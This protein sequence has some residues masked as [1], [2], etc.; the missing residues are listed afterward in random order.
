MSEVLQIKEFDAITCEAD[1]RIEYGKYRL[2]RQN[3]DDLMTFVRE[4]TSDEEQADALEFM[5]I[6]YKRNAGDI[7]SF[8][9][10]VGMIQLPII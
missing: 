6:R 5:K 4:Y 10:Y 8:N 7:I 9:N 2:N 1:D 3:F